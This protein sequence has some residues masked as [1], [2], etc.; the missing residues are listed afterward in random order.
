MEEAE[1]KWHTLRDTLTTPT[2]GGASLRVVSP[3]QKSRLSGT[4]LEINVR[5][6]GAVA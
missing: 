4:V 1:E 6:R 3:A 5:V 2:P